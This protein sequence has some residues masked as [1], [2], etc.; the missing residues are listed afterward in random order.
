VPCTTVQVGDLLSH[1]KYGKGTVINVYR[2][3]ASK[4]I[5]IKFLVDIDSP[6]KFVIPDSLKF[7]TKIEEGETDNSTKYEKIECI[8]ESYSEWLEALTIIDRH[9]YEIEDKLYLAMFD[10]LM[11]YV[12]LKSKYMTD[13]IK[14][15]GWY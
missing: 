7:F 2:D 1:T 4:Y 12:G 15:K 6:K 13:R 3:N 14:E 10:R 11:A 5:E 8:V 9:H